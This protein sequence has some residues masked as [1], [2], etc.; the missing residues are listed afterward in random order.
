MNENTSQNTPENSPATEEKTYFEKKPHTGVGMIPSAEPLD[1]VVDSYVGVDGEPHAESVSEEEIQNILSQYDKEANTRIFTGKRKIVVRWA[2]I[3]FTLYALAINTP[4]ITLPSQIHRASYLGFIILL[5]ILMYPMRK[6]DK[7]NDYV[8]WYDFVIGLVGGGAFFYFVFCYEKLVYQMGTITTFDMVVGII[9]ILAL[10]ECCRRVVGIPLMVVVACFIL[11]ALFGYI[12][13]GS[14][15]HSGFTVNRTVNFLFF[16]QEGIL[17]TPIAVCSTF[18]FIFVLFGALLEKTGIGQF[19]IDFANSLA[20]RAVGGPAKVAVI[21]SAL[22]GTISGS[23]V[24][25]TV[26]S[27]SFTIPMMKRMHYRPEFAA[28]VEA[29]S[30]TGGQL[31][32]PIMGAAAF[33]MAEMTGIPYATIILAAAIPAVL[34]F[35]TILLQVHF[36]AKKLGLKGMPAEEIPHTLVLLK[37]KGHLFLAVIAIIVFLALGFPAS[38]SALMACVTAIVMSLFRKDTRIN[39]VRL[40][41]AFENGARNCIGVSIACGMAGCIVGVVTRTGLGFTF[42]SALQGFANGHLIL[43]LFFCMLASIVLGMGVPTTANYVIMA[44]VTAPVVIQ[45]GVPLLAAHMFVFYFGIV[46]DI[47][48]P[49]ALAAYAGSA[50]A[51][52]N[53]LRTGVTASR[54]AICAFIVPYIFALNP[55]MLLIDTTVGAVVLNIVTALLGT[56]LIALALTG[57]AVGRMYWWERIPCAAAGLCMLVPGLLTDGIGI[58]VF[59]ALMALQKI[60]YGSFNILSGKVTEKAALSR[61]NPVVY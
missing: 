22:M 12:I 59:I 26:G 56:S 41:D 21:S 30:S 4:W 47:T 32:P 8:P 14:F 9:G 42:A 18:I 54:L 61:K 10:F 6:K 27:G 58:A 29:T 55:A 44:T 49:V 16:T 19:F 25:N 35:I 51:R 37:E 43:A 34:Y 28:A 2:L 5:A 50:I 39:L 40:L 45:L 23:S 17:G 31:M 52:S 38:T 46:A 13:P 57:F 24:A 1:D 33:L 11:Y 3:C 36:E 7:R 15:G 20:G 60:R 53:P 48:P